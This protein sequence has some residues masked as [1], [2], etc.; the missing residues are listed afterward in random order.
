MSDCVV[1][2]G[3][4]LRLGYGGMH[5][6]D[7]RRRLAHRVFYM[8]YNG[9][10]PKGHEI[11]HT[12]G[13][14]LCVNPRHLVALT[15]AEHTRLHQPRRPTQTHCRRGHAFTPENTY[16]QRE[17]GRGCKTCRRLRDNARNARRRLPIE[18]EGEAA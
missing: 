6:G 16:H 1:W 4:L 11:H 12:C 2:R 18:V 15:G 3:G 5:L 17:E 10:I 14:R 7:G 9:P 13:V 8:L